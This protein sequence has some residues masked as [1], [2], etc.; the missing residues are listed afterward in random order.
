MKAAFAVA[1]SVLLCGAVLGIASQSAGADEQGLMAMSARPGKPVIARTW[2]GK[3]RKAKADEYEQYLTAAIKKFPT[4]KGNLGYQLMRLDSSQDGDEY[5]EFQVISYWVSLESIHAY[6]G[7]DVR[8]ARDLPRD[9]EFL[10]GKEA[11]VRNCE[12]KVNAIRP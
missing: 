6:A 1:V 5:V 12:L 4:I 3:T 9:D 2:H 11:F 8:R 10:V 7:A